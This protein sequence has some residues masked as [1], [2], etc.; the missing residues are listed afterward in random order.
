VTDSSDTLDAIARDV[1]ACSGCTLHQG[2]KN[3]V[4]GEGSGISGIYFI[5]EGPGHHENEQGRPF[6]GSAGQLLTELLESVGLER[7]AVWI[8]NVVRCRPPGNRDPLPDEVDA[9]AVYTKRQLAVLQPKVI[10]TLG[11]HA[12]GRFLPGESISRVHGQPR[13]SGDYV[14]FP[15]YHPAAALHQ[16]SLRQQLVDDFRKLSEFLERTP[17]PRAVETKREEPRPATQPTLF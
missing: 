2:R 6:V 3:A 8:T 5:G 11:R 7:R 17:A 10:V 9:C 15:M 1:R 13:R 4:P 14:V 16:P 12:M